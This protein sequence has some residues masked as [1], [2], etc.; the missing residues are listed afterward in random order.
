MPVLA[1]VPAHEGPP[2]VAI[3]APISVSYTDPDGVLWPWPDPAA[4]MAVT[5]VT[6]IGSAPA[7]PQTLTLPTGDVLVQT[8]APAARQ[9]VVGLY[10]EAATQAGLLDVIDRLAVALSNDRAGLPAPGTLIFS[11]PDGT[12]R[13][14]E[15]ICTSGAD[16]PDEG[17][18]DGFRYWTTYGLTFQ[19]LSP[20]F[21]DVN[22]IIATWQLTAAGTGVPPMPPVLL[23]AATVLGVTS[24]SNP[25]DADAWPV[26][27]ITGPGTPTLQNTSTGLSFGLSAALGS[28]EA[29]TVDTRPGK[30][31]ATDGLGADRWGDL[32]AASPRDLWQLVPGTN[33][34]DLSISGA[35]PASGISLSF[36]P[37]HRRA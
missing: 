1:R 11:R 23:S 26:W 30:V 6:G 16:Q 36:R 27:T 18:S 19:P 9:I 5:S 2:P 20:Y 31:S 7:A 28:G 29:V 15:V 17:A 8:V 12:A 24:I 4:G 13:Q 32:V 14:V 33:G 3:P 35:T 10:V 34:L 21:E 22:P 25:G 37:R